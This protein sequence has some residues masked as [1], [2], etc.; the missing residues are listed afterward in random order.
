MLDIPLEGKVYL[1]V[2]EATVEVPPKKTRFRIG[3]VAA[4]A[5]VT[6]KAIRFYEA[7]GV[8]PA[9]A[10]GVNGYRLYLV[11]AVEMLHFIR[12]ASGLGLSLA[13]IRD[14][15]AIRQGGRAPCVHVRRLLK[16]KALELDRKLK[17]LEEV[18]RRILQTLRAAKRPAK[19]RAAVCA[20]IEAQRGLTP[21]RRRA[22]ES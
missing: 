20:H 3:Q 16:D 8:L 22:G 19:G 10:R 14:I 6:A 21:L 18:R 2:V 7:A 15:I 11:D 13:E 1:G 12:Q 9:P 5:G 4:R 17:D